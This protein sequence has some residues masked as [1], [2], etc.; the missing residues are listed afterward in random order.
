MPKKTI[1]LVSMDE[2]YNLN[3]E[4]PLASSLA[5]FVRLEIISDPL[6]LEEYQQQPVMA[7]VLI[8]DRKMQK[9]LSSGIHTSRCYILDEDTISGR[10]D[11]ISKFGGAPAIIRSLPQE[12][13]KSGKLSM[14]RTH[15]VDVCSLSGGSGKTAAAICSGHW[16][17][18][19]G[20]RV[21]YVNMEPFQNYYHLLEKNEE[22]RPMSPALIRSMAMSPVMAADTAAEEMLHDEIDMLPQIEGLAGTYQITMDRMLALVDEIAGRQ[23]YDY[24]IVEYPAG[25]TTA[26]QTR[27]F[28]SE[29]LLLTSFQGAD[30]ADRIRDFHRVMRRFTG[31]CVVT[32][33]CYDEGKPDELEKCAGETGFPVCEKVPYIEGYSV[34]SLLER[35]CYKNT[36]AAIC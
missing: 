11:H 20:K 34:N 35:G 4:M 12:L 1:L 2:E 17:A 26:A 22:R 31:T 27:L 23:I 32:S 3:I 29:S 7:D 33:D 15:I 24:I 36:A 21:L 6:Y 9:L 13:L 30:H 14:R 19:R 25:F 18:R 16:L 8:I 10:P 28:S 5:S